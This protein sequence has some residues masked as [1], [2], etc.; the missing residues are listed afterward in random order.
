MLQ[1]LATVIKPWPKN[2]MAEMLNAAASSDK[3]AAAQW[4]RARGAAWPAKFAGQYTLAAT[5]KTVK[6]CWSLSAVQWAVAAGSGWL[7]WLCGDYAADRY[8][9]AA[10][11]RKATEILQWAHAKG[12]PCTCGRQQQQQQ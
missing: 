2:I 7:D 1:W 3:L 9:S 4:L 6:Q 11:Q 5:D 8:K 12:C 10:N